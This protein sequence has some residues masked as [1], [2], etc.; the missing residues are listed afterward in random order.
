MKIVL[1]GMPGAGKGTQAKYIKDNYSLAHISTG[2]M[3]REAIATKTPMGIEAKKYMDRGE[4]VPDQVVVGMVKERI[5]QPD[6]KNGFI[7]DGFPRTT[8]QAQEFDQILSE[9]GQNLDCVIDFVISQ[10]EAVRRLASRRTCP[11]CGKI[12]SLLNDT[13]TKEGYCNKCDVPLE[14]R[15]DDHEEVILNRL[16]VYEQQTAVLRDFYSQSGLLHSFDAEKS[17]DEIARELKSVLL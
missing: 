13:F 5:Q 1:L 4:L 3:F 17:P 2:E 11:S 6:C 7:L 8:A 9:M 16:K 14:R 12:Y 15:D 10:K